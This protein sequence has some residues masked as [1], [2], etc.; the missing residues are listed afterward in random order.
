MKEWLIDEKTFNETEIEFEKNL[1]KKC[2]LQKDGWVC[3]VTDWKWKKVEKEEKH[4]FF[5]K[6]IVKKTF[7]V[8]EKITFLDGRDGKEKMW[9][10]SSQGL[11]CSEL[12]IANLLD[13]RNRYL[14]MKENLR[15]IGANIVKLPRKKKKDEK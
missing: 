10:Q 6:T 1:K 12:G 14:T 7:Y 13:S 4:G 11:M 3:A 9:Y 5:K 8:I 2:I 15:N